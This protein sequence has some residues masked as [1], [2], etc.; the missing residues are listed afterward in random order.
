MI[1]T[2]WLSR[3]L[4]VVAAVPMLMFDIS[5]TASFSVALRE[6]PSSEDEALSASAVDVSPDPLFIPESSALISSCDNIPSIITH[7]P[8]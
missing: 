1:L 3:E 2:F 4:S 8:L 5:P 7:S 6:N